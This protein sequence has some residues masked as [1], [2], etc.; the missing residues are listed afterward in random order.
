VAFS[1]ILY[2]NSISKI[3]GMIM[4]N[5][6]KCGNPLQEGA[7]SCPICGTNVLENQSQ[8]VAPVAEPAPAVQPAAK[9]VEPAVPAA[10]VAPAQPAQPAP[11]EQ[12]AV[13]PAAPAPVAPAPASVEQPAAPAE[14]TTAAIA[15]TVE[16]VES[17]TPVPGIPASLS[18]ESPV[19]NAEQPLVENPNLNKKKKKMN[20]L[21]IVLASVVII[22]II[23]GMTLMPGKKTTKK[24]NNT[25]TDEIATYEM[26]SNGYSIKLAEGWL[27]KEDGT[28]VL[29]K[30]K[31]ETVIIKLEHSTTNLEKVEKAN[32]ETIMKNNENYKDVEVSEI[33]MSGRNSFLVN[34][35]INELP[36]Q[37]Y[38]IN[39]GNNLMVGATIVYQSG[40][41]KTKY[42]AEVT[43]MIG[44]LS[45]TVEYSTRAIEEMSE[46][47]TMF[48]IFGNVANN[49]TTAPK[50][51]ETTPEPEQPAEETQTE[52]NTTPEEANTN[53]GEEN[54]ENTEDNSNLS[55]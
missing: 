48:N 9:P 21:V 36:V 51:E 43:E 16:R 10:P 26:A 1:F 54:T 55:E 11:V 17:P 15:P 30:N 18:T 34:T 40:D 19:I 20:P 6:P 52:E 4:N 22:G 42:E 3:G 28:N 12:P 33:N 45:Y 50:E 38:L 2:Y 44:T 23:A 32:I 25:N 8:P 29:I 14:V 35:S 5:C 49:I 37:V 41:T 47:S 7:T 13:Q 46:Y 24:A 53:S 31:E 39:G 27:I